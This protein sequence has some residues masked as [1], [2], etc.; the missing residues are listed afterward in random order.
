MNHL[1]PILLILILLLLVQIAVLYRNLFQV[2]EA[3]KKQWIRAES[4]VATKKMFIYWVDQ[5][6]QVHQIVNYFYTHNMK[7]IVIYGMTDV[8]VML[9]HKLKDTDIKVVCCIDRSKKFINLPIQIVKPKEFSETVDAIVVTSIYYFSEIYD[10]MR[11]QIGDDVPIL[12][13][14]EILYSF[15]KT[16]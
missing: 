1:I 15:E 4:N 11:Q 6:I 14:D 9:Y 10:T 3:E 2:R 13:L 16:I 12:G 7:K 8:G 5:E